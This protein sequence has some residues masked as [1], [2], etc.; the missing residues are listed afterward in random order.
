MAKTKIIS[1]T[2][3]KGGV[4]K[5]TTTYN[6]AC[7]LAKLGKKVLVVDLDKQCNLST[8]CG[9]TPDGRTTISDLVYATC[10]GRETNAHEAI[11]QSPADIDYISSSK[12]LDAIN[13][14]IACDADSN[15]VLKRIFS[16]DAFVTY[17]YIIFDNKPAIDILTQNALNASDYVIIPIEAGI[18]AFDG[19]DSLLAKIN[20]LNATTNPYLK[21][22][23]ILYN[24]A[25]NVTEFGK[26][27]S[28]ATQ[29][30]YGNLLFNTK[31]PNRKAQT[32]RAIANQQG[33][34]NL[35]NN[36]LA[37]AYM[38]LANEVVERCEKKE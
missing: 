38:A 34:V 5:T 30:N 20:S 18:F 33:C 6:L 2:N 25:E 27:I 32:E 31:I 14:Q 11:H 23:G 35:K 36:T 7:G 9:Y 24:K 22:L 8:T 19:I 16:S 37:D 29:E 15:Y 3:E 1:V 12:M 26:A 10:T 28:A 17:D 4:G 13:S 21:V